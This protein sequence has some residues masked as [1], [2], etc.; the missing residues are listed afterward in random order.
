MKQTVN[1][2]DFRDA[3]QACNRADNFSYEGL[4]ALFDYLEQYE[5]G[6]G[7][8]YELDVI[9]LCCD[10]TEWDSLE[11]FNEYYGGKSCK[12]LE[13][14]AELTDVIDINGTRFITQGF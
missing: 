6:T 1:V 7:E 12:T 13:D 11:E 8:E 4:T 3:F 9:A 14:V 5:E 2:Y 10:F